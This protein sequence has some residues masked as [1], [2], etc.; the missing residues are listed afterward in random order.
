VSESIWIDAR[1]AQDYDQGLRGIGRYVLEH[2][3]ALI[4]GYPDRIQGVVCE[5]TEPLPERLEWLT[6]AEQLRF[7][8]DD[9]DGPPDLYHVTSAFEPLFPYGRLCPPGVRQPRTRLVVTVYDLIPKVLAE[10]RLTGARATRYEARLRLL[11]RADH[12][13]CISQVTAEDVARIARVCSDRIT[14]IDAGVTG[15]LDRAMTVAQAAAVLA[16]RLPTVRRGYPLYVGG[17]DPRKNLEM[18]VRAWGMVDP[19]IRA[20]RPL[21]V[22]GHAPPDRVAALQAAAQSA[23]LGPEELVQTGYVTDTELAALYV[24]CGVFV[25]PSIYEGFGMPM[26]E[27]MAFGVPVVAARASTTA[28]ILGDD[29]LTFDPYDPAEMARTIA[30]SL[31]DDDV[32]ARLKARSR[33]RSACYTWSN[34]ADRT[35]EA[36]ERT[37]ARPPLSRVR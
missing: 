23:G 18:L 8:D 29:D 9:H 19:V 37:L 5:R 27:A 31:L 3:R 13:L 35:I 21:V 10:Y 16:E 20:G 2:T 7:F 32:R 34:V 4:G 26:L 17:A 33:T 14:V 24:A 22:C 1:P 36:Y 28:E 6:G 11:T 15:T 30:R 12:V 25:F